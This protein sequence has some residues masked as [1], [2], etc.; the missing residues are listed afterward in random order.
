VDCRDVA[1][2]LD[3]YPDEEPGRGD[4]SGGRP[5]SRL[6][7]SAEGGGVRKDAAE[8]SGISQREETDHSPRG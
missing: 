8:L 4:T 5:V 3:A 7:E 6:R 1:S 2:V